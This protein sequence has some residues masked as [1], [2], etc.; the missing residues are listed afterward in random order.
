M[1]VLKEWII[2]KEIKYFVKTII[3]HNTV[4]KYWKVK[5]WKEVSWLKET[6]RERAILKERLYWWL[7][8]EDIKGNVLD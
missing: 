8:K 5:Q 2:T 3:K 4:I 1:L 7:F 6:F